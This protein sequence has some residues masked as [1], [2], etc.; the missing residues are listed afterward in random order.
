MKEKRASSMEQ[1][2]DLVQQA[3]DETNDLLAAAE[4]DY[5]DMGMVHEFVE[6]LMQDLKNLQ[7]AL[8]DGTH[9]FS[10]EDLPF[11]AIVEAQ[12]DNALPF[13]F[14]LRMINNTHRLGLAEEES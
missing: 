7:A 13:K 6:P 1:F 12:N 9:A 10:D 11:M 5:E 2:I 3:V 4:Y 8:R 14:L